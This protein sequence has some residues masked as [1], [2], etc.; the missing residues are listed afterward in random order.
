MSSEFFWLSNLDRILLLQGAEEQTGLKTTINAELKMHDLVSVIV[1]VFNRSCAVKEALDSIIEQTYQHWEALVVDDGSTDETPQV[2][3]KYTCKD[4]RIHLLQHAQ[5][6]GAQ[7]ARNIGIRAAQGQWIA[8]LDSDDRWLPNSLEV[9]LNLAKRKGVEVVH[10]ECFILTAENPIAG[11]FGVPPIQGQA[12]KELLCRPGPMFQGLLVSKEALV[13]IG[14]LDE[15]IVSHQEWDTAIRLAKYYE[16]G[17]VPKPTF[18]YDCRSSGTI[19]KD[20]LRTAQGYEQVFKKHWCSILSHAGPWALS[21]HYLSASM[22]YRN[23]N[24]QV[25]A[26]RCLLIGILL[27]PFRPEIIIRG[28]QHL[29]RLGSGT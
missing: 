18:I 10:S 22:L 28:A 20:P 14:Y 21:S 11:L 3:R 9:R 1:P 25:K 24:E 6:Q 29:L 23:A 5:K 4:T 17:F 13:R 16:F 27:W 12:Y 19:S 7:A 26:I 2:I 8:F 15:K